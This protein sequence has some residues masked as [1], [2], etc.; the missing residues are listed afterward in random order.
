MIERVL[1]MKKVEKTIKPQNFVAMQKQTGA[2][3]HKDKKKAFKNGNFKH[4]KEPSSEGS[5]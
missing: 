5:F 1:Q 3:C 2:G 4:K